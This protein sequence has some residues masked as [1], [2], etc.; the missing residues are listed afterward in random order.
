MSEQPIL[1]VSG[2]AIQLP[3]GADRLYAVEHVS[4]DIHRGETLAIVG[5]SGSGKSMSANAVMGLL[6]PVTRVAQGQ[7]LLEGEDVLRL[8]PAAMRAIRGRRIGMIFQEP[9]TAL[10]PLMRVGEQI[11]EVFEAHGL[12]STAE[13]RARAL[14]LL[15]EVAFPSPSGRSTPIPSSSPAAAPARHDRHGAGARSGAA[16]RRRADHGAGRD[17][18]GADPEAD[19]RTAG[20]AWDGVM[21][22]THDFGVVAD[23]ADRVVV[24][25]QGRVVETGTA[26]DVLGSPQH[27]YTQALIAAIPTGRAAGAPAAKAERQ[28]V[29]EVK[30]LTKTYTSPT[31]FLKPP[32]VVHAVR[33]VSFTLARGETLGVVGESGSGKSSLG[34]CLVR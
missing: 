26:V 6:P 7:A 14:A 8:D 17:D 11:A 29:L 28:V 4:F 2:L 16:D 23:I 22:I 24:M 33:D 10:D 30:G 21:F 1:S 31:G 18:A 12:Y 5:E 34:R 19:P 9:M 3:A 27:E 25:R 20:E 15:T 13:R 32:R